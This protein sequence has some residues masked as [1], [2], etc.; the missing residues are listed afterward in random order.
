[1]PISNLQ[2]LK[3]CQTL[4]DLAELLGYEA[5]SLSYIIYK[6]TGEQ[7]Y[8]KFDIPKKA[9]GVRTVCAPEPRLKVLQQKVSQLLQSCVEEL[10]K[11]GVVGHDAAGRHI[12]SHGFRKKLSIFTNADCHLKRRYVLNADLED[13]FG[14]INF[15]R[16]RGFFIADRDF[17]LTPT[18]ATLIAQIACFENALPQGSP[19]SPVIS[20]L[21]GG[22][23]DVHLRRMSI[24]S[25]CSYTRY[26][27]DMTFSTNLNSFPDTIAL[28]NSAGLWEPGGELKHF[29]VK[30]G[31]RLN[32]P[33]FR[34]QMRDS[35]QMV[36]GLV[37]NRRV[38]VTLKH[39]RLLRAKVHNLL[40]TG[41]YEELGKSSNN[42]NVLRG[43]LAFVMSA[44]RHHDQRTHQSRSY[45][46]VTYRKF[47]FYD[48]F[49]A[50]SFPVLLCE[51]KTDNVYLRHASRAQFTQLPNLARVTKK[52]IV[53]LQFRFVQQNGGPNSAAKLLG[54]GGGTPDM[55]KFLG[56]YK[57]VTPDSCNFG[58]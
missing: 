52:G 55:A 46:S 34:M 40:T 2:S 57:A 42:L 11:Y 7:K 35:R 10:P 4:S 41:E 28:V 13:F 53:E 56:E 32:L 8:T 15:G 51:G 3:S 12:V 31:Y 26:A 43:H 22:I 27:D 38:N 19:C 39:R 20:N 16:V 24:A 48:R 49:F 33:K 5:K 58:P 54:L 50:S 30:N 47:L 21:L 1:M 6:R 23:L 45:P 14:S 17:A 29:I 37:V 9:G 36:T 25:K 18:V 44:Q